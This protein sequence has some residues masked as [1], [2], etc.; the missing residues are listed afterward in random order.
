MKVVPSIAPSTAIIGRRRPSGTRSSSPTRL[1]AVVAASA[2]SSQGKG[3]PSAAKT[4]P[5][6][7]PRPSAAAIG[8]LANRPSSRLAVGL[9]LAI[10]AKL[11]CAAGPRRSNSSRSPDGEAMC[12]DLPP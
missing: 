10:A 11:A 4:A 1:A 6:K 9:A 3:R 7:V 12:R 2:P 8:A 5:P